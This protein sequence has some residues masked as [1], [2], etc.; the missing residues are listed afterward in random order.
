MS[1]DI[2]EIWM[3]GLPKDKMYLMIIICAIAKE[4]ICGGCN[5]EYVKK[6]MEE[7]VNALEKMWN[8]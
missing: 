6:K 7:I 3:E 2:V 4:I 5:P 1:E 8:D